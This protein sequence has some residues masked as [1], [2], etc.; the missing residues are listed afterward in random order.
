MCSAYNN[1]VSLAWARHK[2]GD[3][4]LERAD[5]FD[6]WRTESAPKET[7]VVDGVGIISSGT[8]KKVRRE[9][10]A[11]I[12]LRGHTGS[13]LYVPMSSLHG[14][15]QYLVGDGH[16]GPWPKKP[17]ATRVVPRATVSPICVVSPPP[18]TTTTY[19]TS[20]NTNTFTTTS[21]VV[22]YSNF[23]LLLFKNV[24]VCAGLQ[25]YVE[26]AV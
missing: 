15:Q 3:L 6:F 8:P 18:T 2:S 25:S 14:I 23:T 17:A 1:Y 26:L 12:F 10:V 11:R 24:L 20:T 4:R 7:A 5:T 22:R 13:V 21:S 19:D 16:K 9:V